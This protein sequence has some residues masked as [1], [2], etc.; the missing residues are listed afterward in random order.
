MGIRFL[1][2]SAKVF[3]AQ[4][5]P[6]KIFGKDVDTREALKGRDAIAWFDKVWKS[7]LM[8]EV[9]KANSCDLQFVRDKLP[10]V[11]QG[12]INSNATHREFTASGCMFICQMIDDD[13]CDQLWF[14][15]S[16]SGDPRT[17]YVKFENVPTK[18]AFVTIAQK[19][20]WKP[21]ELAEKILIDFMET[22][23]RGSHRPENK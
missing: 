19:L 16:S 2:E 7:T 22:V 23:T 12:F 8:S 20:Q 3:L 18:E 11:S 6:S 13:I 17:L 1:N 21:E 10:Q 4:K 5:G 9:E 15:P 14:I